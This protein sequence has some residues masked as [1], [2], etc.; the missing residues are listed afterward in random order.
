MFHFDLLNHDERKA[1]FAAYAEAAGIIHICLLYF[2]DAFK[3]IQERAHADGK[4]H[5]ATCLM[6]M[7]DFADAIDGV[8][9]LI[10]NGSAA[11]CV[12]LLRTA[13]EHQLSLLYVWQSAADYERRSLAYEAGHL[14]KR[15]EW[16]K[17]VDPDTQVGKQLR[18]EL[19]DD[20][21]I[22]VFN[23]E[24]LDTK[25]VIREIEDR[26]KSTRYVEVER[27]WQRLK[28]KHWFSLWDGPKNAEGLAGHLKMSSAYEAL[29]RHWSE[30]THAKH[31]LSR[32]LGRSVDGKTILDPL[33]SPRGLQ[34]ICRHASIFC[35][36][37]AR[38]AILFFVPEL[39]P[40]YQA[41]YQKNLS[42]KLKSIKRF[43]GLDK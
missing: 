5:H 13:F 6:L 27:E 16:A 25:K 43:S 40:K 18:A 2:L 20:P 26:L 11:N 12:H 19:K 28:V 7:M 34:N 30:A 4:D 8:E 31:A 36:H 23:I 24:G 22:D 29:Y 41:H 32:I 14:H 38:V 35:V 39:W 37:L 3:E 15:L 42:S 1:H 9:V 21:Y 17:K 33:R 10:A